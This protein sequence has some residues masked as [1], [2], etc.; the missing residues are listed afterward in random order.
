MTLMVL[1]H[2]V[3]IVGWEKRLQGVRV[4]DGVLTHL[5]VLPHRHSVAGLARRT[6]SEGVAPFNNHFNEHA[7][8]PC[9]CGR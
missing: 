8:L 9:S 1:G 7:A 4:A 6:C 3:G 5:M 2:S